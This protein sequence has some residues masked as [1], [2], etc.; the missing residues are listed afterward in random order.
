MRWKVVIGNLSSILKLFG[1]AFFIPIIP[2]ISF[3]EEPILFG[4]LPFNVIIFLFMASWTFSL[5]FLFKSIGKIEDFRNEEAIVIVS[6]SWL[7]LALISS[8]P[9]LMIGVFQSPV[10]AFFEAMS[11]MTTT[12][13]T[14]IKYPLEQY[15]KSIMLWR[16]L[17]QWMGGMGV[18]V[19]SVA[20]LTK[21]SRGGLTLLE[22]EAPGPSITRLKPKIKETAKILWYIYGLLTFSLV[23]LLL[24]AGVT[25]YNAVYHAFTTLS[26]GGFSPH[27]DSIGF[28]PPV[29]HWIIIFFMIAAGMNFSLHFQLFKGNIK[30]VFKNPELRVYLFLIIIGTILTAIMLIG[31]GM[32]TLDAIREGMFQIL[33]IITTTGYA[34]VDFYNDWPEFGRMLLL[35]LMFVGGSAGS[36]SGGIKIVRITLIFKM[37]GRKFKEFINPR[38]VTVVRMGDE[39]ITESML[40]T[41]AMFFSAY[42]IIFVIGAL[43][44]V[45][46]G[47][48]MISGISATATT[49]G[50]VG[51]GLG[52]VGPAENFRAVPYYGR[53]VLALLMWI[54]RLEIFTAI[55]LF[56]PSL[57]KKRGLRRIFRI[58]R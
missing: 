12:G 3:F 8:I 52:L 13:A 24:G 9:F 21:L 20:I 41:V 28:Y 5:S 19:L 32:G 49:I 46:L 4:F 45:A 25:P 30:R 6:S 50:N 33:A 37:I 14:V 40:N 22:S 11:G 10:N 23:I 47:M 54:G 18:I 15:P 44:M 17:L 34:T 51:P 58:R 38:R 39:V 57:Y 55:V 26:T 56:N 1:L 48:D 31:T 16:G 42:L 7:I 53:L 27:T 35:V 36:T 29:V 43:I 2:A